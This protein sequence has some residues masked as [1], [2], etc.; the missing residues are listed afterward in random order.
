MALD[1]L[2][3]RN[4]SQTISWLED[5]T[6]FSNKDVGNMFGVDRRTIVN[7]K[8]EKTPP[9]KN[10][11]P[12]VSKLQQFQFL[13]NEVFESDE[14]FED[15]LLQPSAKLNGQPPRETLREGNLDPLLDILSSYYNGAFE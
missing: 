2:E 5:H 7:W 13:V 14:Q 9:H 12:K 3:Q 10:N 11:Q 6:G 1:E 8:T 4:T 15:W